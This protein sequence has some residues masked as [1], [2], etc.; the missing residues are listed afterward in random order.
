MNAFVAYR[1]TA[2]GPNAPLNDTCAPA[3]DQQ[4]SAVS[5][6]AAWT[7]AG[8]PAHKIV[9]GVASY[10]HSF[11]VDAE[12][13]IDCSDDSDDGVLALYPP[14]VASKQPV[15]DAWHIKNVETGK[16][17]SVDG[18]HNSSKIHGSDQPSTWYLHQEDDG[19]V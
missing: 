1:S 3:A 16:Y 19:S 14:F 12:D 9:L 4:G 17:A 6:V 7:A 11:T 5:A 13:A 15:G 2:V 10:G 18:G 8:M